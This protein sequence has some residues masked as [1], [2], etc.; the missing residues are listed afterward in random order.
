MNV[1]F[2]ELEKWEEKY[3]SDRLKGHK[4]RF[5]GKITSKNAAKIKDVEILS[6]F[7]FSR[8]NK[9]A[10]DK[11][12]KLKMIA[13]MS[14]GFDHIDVEE[15]K[16]RK[17][18]VCNVPTYG[19]NT[20]AEHAVALLLS[21]IKKTHLS[22]ERTVRGDFSREGLRSLDLKGK[23]VGVVGCGN[24]GMHFIKMMKGFEAKVIAF[25]VNQNKRL[26]KKLGFKYVS[27]DY[28]LK[29]SDIISLHAPLNPKT[30][31]MIDLNEIKKMKKGVH[32]INT[33]RGGL[34]NPKAL[35]YGLQ[36]K[37]VAGAGLDVLEEECHIVEDKEVLSPHF[38]KVCDPQILWQ[39]HVLGKQ[40]EVL[41]TPHN[42]F[43]SWEALQRI[44]DTTL[45]NVS[46]FVKGKVKNKVN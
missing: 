38:P 4:L 39:N 15:C 32:I 5:T 34:I 17:I 43:N 23:T 44:L 26:A 1:T 21:L 28:L 29:N 7:V 13:A 33:A 12:P 41:I 6:C 35:L 2:A 19:E 16:K 37:I 46:S 24:I 45:V 8:I 20:V 10:L 9:E 14:T 22:H 18:M 40:K 3:V 31:H 25:D 27:F 42:A 30:H 36:K 11:L